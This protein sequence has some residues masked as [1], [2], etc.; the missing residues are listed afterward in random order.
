ML[1]RDIKCILRHR[2]G[3]GFPFARAL[4]KHGALNTLCASHLK[5]CSAL[6]QMEQPQG[7]SKTRSIMAPPRS[8]SAGWSSCNIPN[9]LWVRHGEGAHADHCTR[10]PLPRDPLQL[11]LSS[12]FF[13][14]PERDNSSTAGRQVR[15]APCDHSCSWYQVTISHSP[16][17]GQAQHILLS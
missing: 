4:A 10:P 9:T 3:L 11:V 12:C 14:L 6:G 16:E 13:I 2:M 8:C 1:N 17:C 5:D 15:L 7:S